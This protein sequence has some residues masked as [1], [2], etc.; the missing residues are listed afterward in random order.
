[1]VLF[2]RLLNALAIRYPVQEIFGRNHLCFFDDRSLPLALKSVGFE[3]WL[4][5]LSPYDPTR[6]GQYIS[7][8]DL[9]VVT[10]VEWLGKPL[11]R[12]FLMLV[13]AR[14]PTD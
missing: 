6:P 2:A 9:A 3:V 14:K 7:A 11:N 1:M 12:V 5:Q 4:R 13:Y 8:L 10:L